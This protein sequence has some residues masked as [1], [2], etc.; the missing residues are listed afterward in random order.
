MEFSPC[1]VT[2]YRISKSQTAASKNYFLVAVPA[3][4]TMETI[5]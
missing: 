5:E 1:D 4:A 3:T 2:E